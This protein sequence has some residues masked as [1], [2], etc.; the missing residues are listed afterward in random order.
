M[1]TPKTASVKD[2][3]ECGEKR[4]RRCEENVRVGEK[5]EG[6]GGGG[7]EREKKK[8]KVKKKPD[9]G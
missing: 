7:D 2:S 5:D 4:G 1:N 6:G 8:K 3:G 9:E